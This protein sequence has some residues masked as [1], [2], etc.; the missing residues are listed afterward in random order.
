[1]RR[2]P[3]LPRRTP[4][5]GLTLASLLDIGSAVLPSTHWF[6]TLFDEGSTR[7]ALADLGVRIASGLPGRPQDALAVDPLVIGKSFAE[8]GWPRALVLDA[9]LS[10]LKLHSLSPIGRARFWAVH[11]ALRPSAQV[12]VASES[13]LA[14]MG[15]AGFSVLHVDFNQLCAGAAASHADT[16]GAGASDCSWRAGAIDNTLKIEGVSVAH[17]ILLVAHGLGDAQGRAACSRSMQRQLEAYNLTAVDAL[18]EQSIGLSD[19]VLAA[20]QFVAGMRARRFITTS[21][22][23]PFSAAILLARAH[24]GQGEEDFMLCGGARIPLAD[25]IGFDQPHF[26]GKLRKWVFVATS[27]GL[28]EQYDDLVRVAVFSALRRTRLIPVCIWIGPPSELS[29]WLEARGVRVL[30]HHEPTWQARIDQVIR[31]QDAG[32]STTVPLHGDANQMVATFARIDIAVLGFA[33]PFVLYADVDVLFQRDVLL[34]HFRPLPRYFTTSVEMDYN[35][36]RICNPPGVFLDAPGADATAAAA[37][38]TVACQRDDVNF[39]NGVLLIN[40]DGMRSNYEKFV[41]YVFS[42]KSIKGGLHFGR[43]GM[44][45]QVSASA[46]LAGVRCARSTSRRLA[47]AGR[48]SP[49][50]C[51]CM[52]AAITTARVPHCHPPGG[53]SARLSS[54]LPTRRL[55]PR[56]RHAIGPVP[57]RACSNR[58]ARVRTLQ[59]AFNSFYAGRQAVV[60][61][62]PLANWKAYWGKSDGRAV[63]LHFHGPKPHEYESAFKYM[64]GRASNKKLWQAYWQSLPTQPWGPVRWLV[65]RCFAVQGCYDYTREWLEERA[66]ATASTQPSMLTAEGLEESNLAPAPSA[67]PA[68]LPAKINL[69]VAQSS[70]GFRFMYEPVSSTLLAG[71]QAYR[72]FG[73]LNFTWAFVD[74]GRD[75]RDRMVEKVTAHLQR[76][77]VFIWLGAHGKFE[78]GVPFEEL[79]ERGVYTIWFRTEPNEPCQDRDHAGIDETWEYTHANQFTK[80]GKPLHLRPL[81]RFIP[82]GANNLSTGRVLHPEGSSTLTF[83][84]HLHLPWDPLPLRSACYDRL[85]SQLGPQVVKNVWGIMSEESWKQRL[86]NTS[87]FLNVHKKVHSALSRARSSARSTRPQ[88]TRAALPNSSGFG[89]APRA[90][91]RA[92]SPVAPLRDA[93]ASFACRASVYCLQNCPSAVREAWPG[94]RVASCVQVAELRCDRAL[95]AL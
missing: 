83:I 73:E 38:V 15:S 5:A 67:Q 59:G 55:D 87:M 26:P 41:K 69:L 21:A 32:T 37:A 75:M 89:A 42:E 57:A 14:S 64:H 65:E 50:A 47:S 28:H 94:P 88:R 19:D 13:L 49:A 31:S 36:A 23:S 7:L 35:P 20:A 74:M 12:R 2:A 24:D 63:I 17:P 30:M 56:P 61:T 60:L 8:L 93:C 79:R 53:V 29:A 85:L 1:M 27:T 46:S 22:A 52:P 77:E 66:L 43:Y 68:M 10:K 6:T 91:P 11:K 76:G 9:C 86:A 44:L 34:E 54:R 80:C 18:Q 3:L 84:G 45:D 16:D 39:N 90:P 95:R 25:E 4:S 82:A 92:C 81:S 78:R 33:D 58:C 71:F 72:R 40:V 70:D 51:C 48:R 62:K